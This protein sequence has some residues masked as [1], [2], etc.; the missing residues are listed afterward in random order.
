MTKN[1]KM[2]LGVGAVA[3]VGYLVYQNNKSKGFAGESRRP[4]AGERK[5]QAIG[6]IGKLFSRIAPPKRVNYIAGGYDGSQHAQWISYGGAGA[7]G[8][9][10]PCESYQYPRSCFPV[11][12]VVG[13]VTVAQN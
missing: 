3:V 13:T 5:V 6:G 2:L 12:S 9:W 11:G 4:F 10:Y 1:Q 7:S 8:Y